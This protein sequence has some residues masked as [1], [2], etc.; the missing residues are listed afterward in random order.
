MEAIAK[1]ERQLTVRSIL[2]C[3][4]VSIKWFSASIVPFENKLLA[5]APRKGMADPQIQRPRKLLTSSSASNLNKRCAPVYNI[6]CLQA[7]DINLLCSTLGSLLI[8]EGLLAEAQ[9]LLA[10]RFDASRMC[11][12]LVIL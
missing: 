7:S 6:E 2:A 1:P 3:S 8:F 10:T 5:S 4:N 9:A 11:A 12:I